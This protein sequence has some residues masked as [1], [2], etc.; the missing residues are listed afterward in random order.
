LYQLRRGELA[1]WIEIYDLRRA[2]PLE[3]FLQYTNSMASFLGD[4]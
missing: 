4:P 3:R 2:M 1:A